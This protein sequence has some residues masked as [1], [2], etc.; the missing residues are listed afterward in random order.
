MAAHH[1]ALSCYGIWLIAVLGALVFLLIK[2]LLLPIWLPFKII[3]EITEHSSHRRRS[4]RPRGRAPVPRS[5]RP[6]PR[7]YA[8]PGVQARTPEPSP[9][10]WPY[11]A[12]YQARPPATTPSSSRQR[13][14]LIVALVSGSV[15]LMTIF[16]IA[17]GV[18]GATD[19][20]FKS[21]AS[22]TTHTARAGESGAGLAA[23]GPS[24]M[25]STHHRSRPVHK[26]RRSH[27]RPR[28]HHKRHRFAAP[29]APVTTP[30]APVATPS[31]PVASPAGCY[32]I[33]SSG[34]CY[35]PGEFCSSADAGMTGVAGDGE[36]ITCEDN[37][38]L[39]WEPS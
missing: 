6:T 10:T 14:I 35:E 28:R 27:K 15:L 33:A 30:A 34:N 25:R 12:Q 3:M 39:R 36:Q 17:A 5:A 20:Q 32:P 38:G 29:S 7:P 18:S 8:P 9:K 13:N 2:F 19:T 23:H 26:H 16:A 31:A 37:N 4:R 21:G 11:I 1:R 22:R 24:P